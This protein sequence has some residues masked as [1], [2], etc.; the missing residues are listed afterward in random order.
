MRMQPKLMSAKDK[1]IATGSAVSAIGAAGIASLAGLCCV[2]PAIVAV[3]GVSG[4]VAAAGLAPYRVHFAVAAFALIALGFWRSYRPLSVESRSCSVRTGR[5][6]RTV[7]WGSLVGVVA[8]VLV[9]T[10][11]T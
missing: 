5:L 1:Y 3:L 6:V 11:L 10:W 8:L 4:A 9:P 2:S 7:L